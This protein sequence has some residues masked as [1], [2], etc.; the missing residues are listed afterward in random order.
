MPDRNFV[1][2]FLIFIVVIVSACA[3][4]DKSKISEAVTVPLNDLNLVHEKI[5]PVLRAALKHPYALP[6]E[7][8]CLALSGEVSQLD[9]ELGPDLD[10]TETSDNPSLIERGINEA[11]KAAVGVIRETTESV[12]PFRSW[13]RK[14][15]GA[16]RYSKKVASAIAAGIIRRAFLKGLMVSQSC[17]H[18]RI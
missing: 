13:I 14:L 17:Q 6:D 5:P 12:I 7:L 8:N 2:S 3:A 10:A 18:D 11:T 15:S 4:K 1:F 9:E 16:E